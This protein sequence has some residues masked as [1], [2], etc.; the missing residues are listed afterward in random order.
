MSDSPA[1]RV[2]RFASTREA[3]DVSQCYD[4]ITDGDVLVVEGEKAIAV[5]MGAWPVAIT[6]GHGEF[7]SGAM[8][9]ASSVSDGRY[10]G[11]VAVAKEVADELG[12]TIEAYHLEPGPAV[13][14]FESSAEAVAAAERGDVEEGAVLVVV[15]ERAAAVW[16]NRLAVALTAEAGAFQSVTVLRRPPRECAC[17]RWAASVDAAERIAREYRYELAEPAPGHQPGQR[18]VC[19]DGVVRT[20]EA[21]TD[22]PAALV[23]TLTMDDG[24]TFPAHSCELVDAARV[25]AAKASARQASARIAHRPDPQ[26]PA[27]CKAVTDLEDALGYLRHADPDAAEELMGGRT[28]RIT[29]EIPR[30]LVAKG[31]ILYGFGARLTVLDTDVTATPDGDAEWWA[32]VEGVTTADRRTAYREPWRMAIALGTAM[33]DIV[34][35]ER[36]IP[37]PLA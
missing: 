37:E 26:D 19:P 32:K 4:E 12:L 16:M 18:S 27:W 20:V 6:A 29:L 15:F 34:T 24:T 3:Y 30:T 35:V 33:W 17:G 9:S 22:N 23:A 7:H 5:L 14:R 10:A 36:V 28:R 25:A 13:H 8:E 1:L 31:D 11:S 2:H 21:A